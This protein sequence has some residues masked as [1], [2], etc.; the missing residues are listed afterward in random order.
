M[1]QE[2]AQRANTNMLFVSGEDFRDRIIEFEEHL[3]I[4]IEKIYGECYKNPDELMKGNGVLKHQTPNGF[5]IQNDKGESMFLPFKAYKGKQG[6]CGTRIQIG[7]TKQTERGI[8]CIDAMECV[9]YKE[10][11]YQLFSYIEGCDMTLAATT[12]WAIYDN[13]PENLRIQMKSLI[14]QMRNYVRK[15]I[16][17]NTY[18]V[19]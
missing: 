16:N 4:I 13:A 8:V 10:L 12:A 18:I 3:D 14:H 1:L 19:S 17:R 11:K 9:S 6:R 7:L 15:Y 2:C 5:I